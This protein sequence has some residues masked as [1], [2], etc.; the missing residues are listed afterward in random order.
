VSTVYNCEDHYSDRSIFQT[1]CTGGTSGPHP[2][3]DCERSQ[4]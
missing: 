3:P 2:R 4:W 1:V